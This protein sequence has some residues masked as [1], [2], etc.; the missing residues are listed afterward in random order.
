ME[1][2]MIIEKN[3]T[4]FIVDIQGKDTLKIVETP[5]GVLIILKDTIKANPK[6]GDDYYFVAFNAINGFFPWKHT[7]R[8]SD[9]DYSLYK[10][11]NC[12]FDVIEVTQIS[13][14]FNLRLS[15]R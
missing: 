5:T 13:D 9:M 1:G 4:E 7:W 3:G 2:N 10:A 12:F 11:G 6:D 15:T 8:S 14:E